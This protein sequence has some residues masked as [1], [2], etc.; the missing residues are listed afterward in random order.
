LRSSPP[1]TATAITVEVFA[2]AKGDKYVFAVED[3]RG[4]L[5]STV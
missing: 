4:S 3:D 1:T 5:P 2:I